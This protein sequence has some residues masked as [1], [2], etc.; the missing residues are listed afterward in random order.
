MRLSESREV[1]VDEHDSLDDPQIQAVADRLESKFSE[2]DGVL[3]TDE[4][5]DVVRDS[6]ES[7]QDAPVQ[8]FVPLI[9]EHKATRRLRELSRT[10][11]R[12]SKG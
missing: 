8:T 12:A 5:D 4:V 2:G 3:T 1:I 6:A 10:R 7:L 9:A 11:R